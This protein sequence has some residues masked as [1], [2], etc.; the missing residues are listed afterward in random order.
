M[1]NASSTFVSF[2]NPSSR[3]KSC[4]VNSKT[5]EF[6]Q[7]LI[8]KYSLLSL[9]EKATYA[10]DKEEGEEEQKIILFLSEQT[11]QHYC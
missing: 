3:V 2:L 9:T 1:D 11:R 10:K 7:K 4:H 8:A 5:N 6:A